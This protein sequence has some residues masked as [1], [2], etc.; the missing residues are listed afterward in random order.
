LERGEPGTKDEV[1]DDDNSAASTRRHNGARE[2]GFLIM[3][4]C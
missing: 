2:S 3:V 4:T 1:T